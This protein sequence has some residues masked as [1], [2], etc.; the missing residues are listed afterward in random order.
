MGTLLSA[1]DFWFGALL[2]CAF[3]IRKFGEVGDDLKDQ[4][5]VPN[6]RA[7]DFLG[8][9]SYT[10]ILT[11]F[12]AVTLAG[13]V[14][15][16]L[17]SPALIKGWIQVTT[18][19]VDTAT[20]DAIA[21]SNYPLWIAAAFMG[22]AHQAIPG[23]KNVA[24]FQR[25]VFHDLMGVPRYIV[26]TS[27][28]FSS[29]ILAGAGNSRKALA[30]RLSEL[31]SDK[32]RVGIEPF[33][34]IRF[35]QAEL[36]RLKLD[37][38][39][40]LKEAL[41]ASSRELRV[42]L[43]QVVYLAC[44]ATMRKS[45]G[46]GLA[47][48]ARALRVEKR[49]EDTSPWDL[50]LPALGSAAVLMVLMFLVPMV[51]DPIAWLIGVPAEKLFWPHDK[52]VL[53]GQ[54]GPIMQ[55]A[56]YLLGQVVP[57]LIAAAI[58]AST[59]LRRAKAKSPDGLLAESAGTYVAIVVAVFLYSCAQT[60]WDYG[61]FHFKDGD[62]HGF[63]PFLRDQT[64]CFLLQSLIAVAICMV[65]LHRSA[66]NLE[67]SRARRML[68]GL[69]VVG[70]AVVASAFYACVRL[71]YWFLPPRTSDFVLLVVIL[72]ATA[73]AIA[74]LGCQSIWRR[75]LARTEFRRALAAMPRSSPASPPVL[76]WLSNSTA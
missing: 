75:R 60:L 30:Q 48:L 21:Q 3:Q 33:A 18:G 32:W 23:L 39:E 24:N 76:N 57:V 35:Y 34:D 58:L 9:V 50:V 22:L 69:L 28:G 73:A 54:D 14:L 44:I 53:P 12:L 40:D 62:W 27:A 71:E 20:I 29:Q 46:H 67:A 47:D 72:N 66:Q 38:G 17:A 11:L 36:E 7:S 15:L 2:L 19:T 70:V 52:G 13:Y 1:Y 74:F 65:I 10:G 61:R 16:C 5:A 45:G 56:N 4:V 59:S 8:R 55:S 25:D 31:C 43:Q 51:D 6:L 42:R 26:D 64:P 49:D 37:G 68:D 41:A 63:L